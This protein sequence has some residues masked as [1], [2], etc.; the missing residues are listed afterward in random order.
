MDNAKGDEIDKLTPSAE[1]LILKNM[2]RFKSTRTPYHFK[3]SLLLLTAIGITACAS[4]TTATDNPTSLTEIPP[5]DNQVI[6]PAPLAHT[7]VTGRLTA[8]ESRIGTLESDMNTA[9]PI[10]K[11]VEVIERQFKSLSLNLDHINSETNAAPTN[12]MNEIKTPIV[13]KAKEAPKPKTVKNT[14]TVKNA[15]PAVTNVR[16]GSKNNSSTRIVLDATRPVKITTDLDNNE[17]ILVLDIKGLDWKTAMNKSALGSPLIQS[18]T[19]QKTTNGSRLILQLKKPVTLGN[20]QSL[21]PEKDMGH[22]G[23]IDLT[24]Q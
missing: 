21:N 20:P 9:K 18:Y 5:A 8:L 13:S 24:A 23:F 3:S 11:K 1:C 2:I 4:P 6:N 22:R 7:D 14:S 19:A 17:K 16:F 10:L 15:A 12:A